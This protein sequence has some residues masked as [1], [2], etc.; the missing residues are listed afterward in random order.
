VTRPENW[1]KCSSPWWNESMHRFDGQV[2]Q[3]E[4]EREGHFQ[5][6]G[7]V[8]SKECSY[9]FHRDWLSPAKP[10]EPVEPIRSW[11]PEGY[12]LVEMALPDV[13][14]QAIGEG[15]ALVWKKPVIGERFCGEEGTETSTRDYSHYY[16]PVLVPT[17]PPAVQYREPTQADVGRMV[18]VRDVEEESWESRELLAVLPQHIKYRIAVD[19]GEGLAMLWRFARIKKDA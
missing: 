8:A 10:P 1:V 16:Y 3:I 19:S 7:F 11:V 18:E 13:M 15:N 14:A 4:R 17:R 2:G 5:I 12:S 6:R 9:I